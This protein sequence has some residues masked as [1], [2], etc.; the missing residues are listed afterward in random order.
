VARFFKRS[1]AVRVDEVVPGSTQHRMQPVAGFPLEVTAVHAVI[2]LQVHD[3]GLD[4]L[5]TLE[6]SFVAG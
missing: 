1:R 4:G 3:D 2:L 6:H 5:P